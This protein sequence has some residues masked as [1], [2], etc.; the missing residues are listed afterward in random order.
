MD[1]KSKVFVVTGGGGGIGREVVL[2]LNQKGAIVAA[3][4]INEAGLQETRELSTTKENISLHTT[5]ITNLSLVKQLVTN[6]K[7][8]HNKINGLINVAGI[9]QPY[10]DIL[11]VDYN[12][13]NRVMNVN[14]FGTLHMVKEFIPELLNEK[15]A[16]LLNVASMGGFLAV[17]GQSIYG[18]SKAA[19]KLLTEGLY[20]ELKN[21]NINVTVVFPGGV[22]TGIA[23]RLGLNI[24]EK[25]RAQASK[26]NLSP[27]KCAEII[28]KSLSTRKMQVFAGNDSK[29]LNFLYRFNSKMATNIITKSLIKYKGK[30]D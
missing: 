29:I 13:I 22:N 27:E 8:Q 11:D 12:T 28:V 21:S 10:I 1:F 19:V 9:I 7:G 20:A 17:P 5:D 6:V 16:Y 4:D 18:A 2:N 23:D 14:F 26:K 24:S 30:T 15:K 3:V 25:E